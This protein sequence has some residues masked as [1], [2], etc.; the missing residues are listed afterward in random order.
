MSTSTLANRVTELRQPKPLPAPNSDIYKFA[1][2]VPAEDRARAGIRLS[3]KL[4]SEH[5]DQG[6]AEI[7][8]SNHPR[9]WIAA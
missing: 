6:Q 9:L 7:E 3:G 2:T 1:E 4:R 5:L 8:L